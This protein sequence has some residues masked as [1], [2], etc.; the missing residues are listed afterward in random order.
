MFVDILKKHPTYV[1]TWEKKGELFIRRQNSSERSF[2]SL[3][4]TGDS[5]A[6]A[7]D[8]PVHLKDMLTSPVGI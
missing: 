4:C 3:R 8:S 1:L 7:S 6:F 5:E 2:M